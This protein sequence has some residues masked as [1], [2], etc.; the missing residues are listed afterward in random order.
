MLPFLLTPFSNTHL[1]LCTWLLILNYEPI[2]SSLFAPT[3]FCSQLLFSAASILIHTSIAH[4]R[5][6]HAGTMYIRCFWHTKDMQRCCNILKVT[7]S[8][9]L[10]QIWIFL[11]NTNIA[12][13]TE[14]ADEKCRIGPGHGREARNEWPTLAAKKK[15]PATF[16]GRLNEGSLRVWAVGQTEW[17]PWNRPS[18]LGALVPLFILASLHHATFWPWCS[19][20]SFH[21]PHLFH[22]VTVISLLSLLVSIVLLF[23]S[24]SVCSACQVNIRWG[25]NQKW[26]GSAPISV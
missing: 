23:Y 19:Y 11:S 21:F 5:H 22:S 2:V 26:K 13:S 7:L 1:Y 12:W 15:P 4:T 18:L 3:F 25:L 24:N 17:L 8:V 14:R 6:S 10:P 9:T 16:G 20:L